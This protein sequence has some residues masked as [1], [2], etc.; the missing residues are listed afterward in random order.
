MFGS[1]SQPSIP[2]PSRN[3]RSVSNT[4]ALTATR[5]PSGRTVT[6]STSIAPPFARTP[7]TGP[8]R[9]PRACGDSP[10]RLGD[11]LDDELAVAAPEHEL[12][13]LLERGGVGVGVGDLHERG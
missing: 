3:A 8:P 4:P 10:L 12:A 13:V 11:V 5:V 9:P 6:W 1:P 2:S 7:E